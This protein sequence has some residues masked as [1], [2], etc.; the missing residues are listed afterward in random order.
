QFHSGESLLLD[1]KDNFN[2]NENGIM[3]DAYQAKRYDLSV[4]DQIS[5]QPLDKDEQPL[6]DKEVIVEIVG[7]MEAAS[8]T[9]NRDIILMPLP[10]Y[11]SHFVDIYNQ[12]EVKAEESNQANIIKTNI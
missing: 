11:T 1:A 9:T 2:Q 3:L 5:L 7:T 12:I 4:G 8:L 10:Y 6:Q